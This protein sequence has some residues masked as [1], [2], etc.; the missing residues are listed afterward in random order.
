MA[1][2]EVEKARVIIR[3]AVSPLRED[4]VLSG[5]IE[6]VAALIR[7]GKFDEWLA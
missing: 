2:R 4:R 6:R 7:E 5:D 1:A 3:E